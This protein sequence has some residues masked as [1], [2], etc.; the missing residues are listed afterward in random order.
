M[1]AAELDHGR[2][3]AHAK[4]RLHGTGL[5]VNAGVND[6]AVVSA[7]VTGNPVFFFEQQEM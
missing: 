2:G 6:A 4:T 5:V 3:S 7:L 1:L